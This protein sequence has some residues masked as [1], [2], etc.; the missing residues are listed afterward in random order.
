M[1]RFESEAERLLAL[2]R[3]QPWRDVVA[4]EA[5]RDPARFGPVTASGA[6]AILGLLPLRDDARVLVAGDPW[7]RLAVPLARRTNVAAL[8][9]SHAEAALLGCVAAQEGVSLQACAG[10]LGAV[11]FTAGAFDAALVIGEVET[12]APFAPLLASGGLCYSAS[13]QS[14]PDVHADV[15]AAG[16]EVVREYACFPD[17][18]TPRALVPIPLLGAH[19]QRVPDELAEPTAP[20]I[21]YVTRRP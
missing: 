1:L 16:L 19:Q 20:T 12:L 3:R 8:L 21:A 10:T 13:V 9:P 2:V 18:I 5:R 7:G 6:A 14:R 4:A 17:D 11:P 15:A